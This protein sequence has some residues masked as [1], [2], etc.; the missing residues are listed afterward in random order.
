MNEGGWRGLEWERK[1]GEEGEKEIDERKE[2]KGRI[3]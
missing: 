3:E 1:M 2:R